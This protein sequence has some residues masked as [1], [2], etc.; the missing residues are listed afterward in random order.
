MA[1]VAGERA[2]THARP[3][4]L[5]LGLGALGLGLGYVG[6]NALGDG[7]SAPRTVL[8]VVGLTVGTLAGGAI[9][10][11]TLAVYVLRR[12]VL[13]LPVLLG[14]TIITFGLAWVATEGD[15]SKSY[16]TERQSVEQR[17]ELRHLM[18]FDRPWYEQYFSYMERLSRLDLGISHSQNDRPVTEVFKQFFPATLELSLVA[19][20]FAVLLGIQLGVVSAVRKDKPVDQVTRVIALS[21]V[22]VPIFWLG[23]MLKIVFASS[24][25][26]VALSASIGNDFGLPWFPIGSRVSNEVIAATDDAGLALHAALIP[27]DPRAT[28]TGFLVID[29]ILARDWIALKDVLWHLVLPGITLGYTSM[30]IITRMM[31]SSMLEVL[32]QDYIRTARAKGLS[33]RDVVHRHARRNAMIPTTTVIGLSFAGLLGGAVLTETIFQWPGLGGW[34]TRAIVNVDVN[35]VLSFTLIVAVITVLAN[36]IVD[37]LYAY[38]DPRVRLG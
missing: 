30:A 23:L 38:F 14:V 11:S 10:G 26:A 24:V 21:G 9:G 8:S 20:F 27:N 18:G 13:S 28:H 37:V 16:V 3:A 36:L 12:L 29:T 35:S 4:L 5:V 33:E 1:T 22:S 32:S 2:I 19:M 6:G 7:A 15:L 34:S 25:V 31:R 17:E